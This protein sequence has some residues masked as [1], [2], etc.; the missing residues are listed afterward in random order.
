MEYLITQYE[1]E[2]GALEIQYIEEYFGE[3]PRKKTAPEIM[4]RLEGRAHLSPGLAVV[5]PE[6]EPRAL[7]GVG[8]DGEEGPVEVGVDRDAARLAALGPVEGDGGRGEVHARPLQ[9]E[10][11]SLAHTRVQ[12]HG[13]DAQQVRVAGLTAGREEPVDLLL[14]QVALA[15]ARLLYPA[16]SAARGSAPETDQGS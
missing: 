15:R 11:L 12:R 14:L 1:L 8:L 6:D 3:F 2:Q 7:R 16:A 5:A 10:D 4:R 13:D 9:A